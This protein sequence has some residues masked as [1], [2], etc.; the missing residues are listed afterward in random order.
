MVVPRLEGVPDAQIS[1]HSLAFFP[2]TIAAS[3]LYYTTN[4]SSFYASCL[5]PVFVRFYD[6][7]FRFTQ[8][9]YSAN[10]IKSYFLYSKAI[11][12]DSAICI[13]VEKTHLLTPKIENLN[14]R[15]APSSLTPTC[16]VVVILKVACP[17]VIASTNGG[18]HLERCVAE[19]HR[20]YI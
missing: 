11:F 4:R 14:C 9:G 6:P 13:L 18:N 8:S 19:D 20:G 17:I 3:S 7:C 15:D 5:L 12:S 2:T 1:G 10:T 16:F